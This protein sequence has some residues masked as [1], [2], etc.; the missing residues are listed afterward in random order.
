M[1]RCVVRFFFSVSF[2]SILIV[3]KSLA[4]CTPTTIFKEDFG[5]GSSGYGPALGSSYTSYNYNATGSLADGDYSIRKTA[6]PLNG[7]AIYSTWH[8]GFDHT[9]NN[10]Y[11]MVINASFNSGKFYETQI[12]NLCSGSTIKF[13]AW[14]AN[15]L[16]LGVSDPLDPNVKFEIKSAVTNIVLGTYTTGI[17]NRYSNFTWQQYGFDIVLPVGETS[18]ILTIYNNQAG[19]LGNDLA[20]DDIEFSICGAELSPFAS[21]T[22]LNGNAVCAGN[23]I[24]FNGGITNL[25]YNNPVLQWQSSIDSNN[26]VNIAAANQSTFTIN[27]CSVGDG[28]WYRLLI[29][30]PG[31][32]NAANCRTTSSTLKL[33]VYNPQPV[34]LQFKNKYC[35]GDTLSIKNGYTALQYN[36]SG[37]NGFSSTDSTVVFNNVTTSLQ[38]YYVLQT[39]TNGGCIN[40]DSALIN[41]QPNQLSLTLSDSLLLCD[42]VTALLATN[43]NFITKWLW[44]NGDTTQQINVNT[45]GLYWVKVWDDVCFNTDSTFIKTNTTPMVN[46][47]NDK[48]ICFS[49][50]LTLN[51]SNGINNY[52]L[53]NDGSTD[54]VYV[55]KNSGTY[56]VSVSNECGTDTDEINITVE[57]CANQI[58][59]PTG[60]TPNGDTKNDVLKP[61][62][63][64]AITDFV[65]RIYDRFGRMVFI[66]TDINQ[67][68]NGEI[69]NKKADTGVYVWDLSY[70]KNGEL[71]HQKGTTVLMR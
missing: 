30:E 8:N 53:W 11:M 6:A 51:A 5:T 16:K 29:A 41:I 58:F 7:Q 4:Q 1:Q 67:G 37:P 54:S 33:I 48:T 64:F 22:Y 17:I 63:Y 12:D 38:G 49:E 47:G 55:V 42:G 21:G 24:S 32:I 13:S 70:K 15:L 3:S 57:T 65:F 27:N 46:L 36:W 45:S 2:L 71:N 14:L 28:K 23:N 19:G 50:S 39:T 40:K 66:S 20:M 10:G 69:N 52:Y 34:A 62:A 56:N 31:N 9:G 68:W 35:V 59:V 60:F 18:V 61:K 26:W 44:S 25:F 43:N